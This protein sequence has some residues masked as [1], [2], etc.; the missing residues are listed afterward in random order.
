MNEKETAMLVRGCAAGRAWVPGIVLAVRGYRW[1][2]VAAFVTS[3][4]AVLPAASDSTPAVTVTAIAP[5]SASYGESVTIKG[6][7]FGGPNVDIRV[8]GVRAVVVGATGA[9]ATFRVPVGVPIGRTTVTVTNPGGRT[10]SIAFDLNGHITLAL[11]EAHRVQQVI[12]AAG[13]V[14]TTTSGGLTYTLM[15]PPGALISD[16]VILMTPVAGMAGLPLDTLLGAVHF[17]PEGLLFAKPATLALTLPAGANTHG[18]VGFSAAGNG[19]HLHLMSFAVRPDGT[20]TIPVLHFSVGGGGTASLFAAAAIQCGTDASLECRFT[21]ALA[22][23]QRQ[24]EQTICGADCATP[25]DLASQE[26]AIETEWAKAEVPLIRDWFTTVLQ[27]LDTFGVSDDASLTEFGHE[28]E[29]WRGWVNANPC[30]GGGDCNTLPDIAADIITGDDHLAADYRSALERA[31]ANCDDVRVAALMSDIVQLGLLG[32][33]GLPG[34][35]AAVQDQF[36]CQLLITASLPATVQP[37]DSIPFTVNVAFQ[38]ALGVVFPLPAADV[39]IRV[40][41]GCG[42]I[43]AKGSTARTLNTTADAT[44]VVSTQI[45][46]PPTCVTSGGQVTVT[47][48]SATVAPG[49]TRLFTAQVQGGGSTEVK[50]S[51]ATIFDPSASLFAL[52][53]SITLDTNVVALATWSASG[54]TIPPGPSATATY[55]A[56]ATTGIFAVTATSVVD[57]TQYETVAVTVASSGVPPP[58]PPPPP[59]PQGALSGTLS[60]S[61]NE[62]NGMPFGTET[63]IDTLTAT[64][65]ADVVN[66]PVLG[67]Y[68]A[69]RS[70]VGTAE[71][72]VSDSLP[73]EPSTD[74]K[75]ALDDV[76]SFGVPIPV[77]AGLT[78][79]FRF[80]SAN[81]VTTLT[82]NS[83][84]RDEPVCI[85][86]VSVNGSGIAGRPFGIS[87]VVFDA[88]GSVIEIDFVVPDFLVTNDVKQ[89][90][91][92][93]GRLLKK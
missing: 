78:P 58:P 34:D 55:T 6:N 9:T 17:S 32:K 50:V 44:G 27:F 81:S 28:F 36:A 61:F 56:G 89:G 47:P 8:G 85:I 14:L 11:D 87:K 91:T 33:G 67:R 84:T 77:V 16:E 70:V 39:T 52:G 69:V 13:G 76:F 59:P 15:I 48:Q 10:A 49:G 43:G 30:G 92:P 19:Q 41:S 18:F 73:C 26:S 23:A 46:I 1:A 54:G 71:F 75:S 37:G 51:V 25:A 7:G 64:V 83:G 24:A 53:R 72:F 93:A 4:V 80:H 63:V 68:L 38:F 2:A 65:S 79:F 5:A 45:Q 90:L 12:G 20:I 29:A 42:A 40:T 3:L 35:Q 82:G 31:H 74:T 66:D 21:H 62:V 88:S 60:Y 22:I 86:D 57:P